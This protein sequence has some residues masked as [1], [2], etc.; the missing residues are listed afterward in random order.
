L[1][2]LALGYPQEAVEKLLKH[3]GVAELKN[4]RIIDLA[5]GTG[6]FTELLVARPEKFE[7]V[8]VEPHEGMRSTLEKKGLLIDALIAAQVSIYFAVIRLE[9]SLLSRKAFHW[10]ST[11][12]AL[13]EIN[14]V[15]IPGG[16]L[17]LI[18]NIEDC[19]LR[20]IV[21]PFEPPRPFPS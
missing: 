18:W 2:D 10:F 11:E 8:A 3:L 6:K 14:R 21:T 19:K 20:D 12:E 16:R 13:K 7:V 5:S 1:T 4:A 15:L 9:M 17:G